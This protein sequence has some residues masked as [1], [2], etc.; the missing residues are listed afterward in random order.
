MKDAMKVS[1]HVSP[2]DPRSSLLKFLYRL[3]NEL[4]GPLV[5]D[6]ERESGFDFLIELWWQQII[7]PEYQFSECRPNL[8]FSNNSE[9]PWERQHKKGGGVLAIVRL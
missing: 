4:W 9:V 6:M 3:P 5:E 2:S 7:A 8:I 1:L